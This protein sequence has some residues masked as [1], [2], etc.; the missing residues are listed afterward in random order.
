MLSALFFLTW[1]KDL[2]FLVASAMFAMLSDLPHVLQT[3]ARVW[4]DPSER[5]LHGRH[6]VLSFALIGA[7]VTGLRLGG[8]LVVLLVVWTYWQILHVLKQHYG[9]LSI[10]AAKNGYRG[11]KKLAKRTLLLGC[12]APV[13]FRAHHGFHFA[14]Y[15]IFGDRLPFSN[16]TVPTP[17]I[18]VVLVVAVYAAFAVMLVRFVREQAGIASA[19]GKA[20]PWIAIATLASAVV[21]YNLS[22]LIVDDLYALILIA[23]TVHSLQYHVI[24][25]A[26]NNAR[27]ERP[28]VPRE[29]R[30]LLLARLSARR[31]LPYY[32]LFFGVAGVLLAAFE[33]RL[34]GIVPL[35]I[36][37]HHFYFDGVV[38]KGSKNPDLAR[39]LAI[40]PPSRAPAAA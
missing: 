16:L 33:T 25:W 19:G 36:V 38:W 18:P 3:S 17:P 20:L 27:F 2:G 12:L 31:A 7:A 4:L 8:A 10:Y 1:W 30:R 22:Y 21:S 24:S 23:T 14:D 15:E 6:F 35:T 40:V 29:D 37:L 5:R 9:I 34:L 28:D 11:Q 32:A 13:L 39:Y 26:R